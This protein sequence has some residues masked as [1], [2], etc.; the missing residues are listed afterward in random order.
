MR[1]RLALV[2]LMIGLLF[3]AAV[4]QPD[5]DVNVLG[6]FFSDNTFDDTTTDFEHAFAPFDSYI[7]ILNATFDAIGGYE[8]SIVVD[9]PVLSWVLDVSGPNG[10][11]NFGWALNHIVGYVTPL[12]SDPDGTVLC[13]MLMLS[14]TTEAQSIYF[15]PAEPSSI[16]GYPTVL[17]GHEPWGVLPCALYHGEGQPVAMVH[18]PLV[19]TQS[20]SL[21][22]VKALFD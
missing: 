14:V 5:P 22:S 13:T 7:V 2:V 10:L 15:E 18:G 3:Q 4:A 16:E 20:R 9:E 19:A 8:L 1:R 6:L 21:T 17:E 12:P 11:I